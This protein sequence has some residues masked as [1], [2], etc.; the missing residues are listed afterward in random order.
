MSLFIRYKP[1]KQQ[2]MALARCKSPENKALVELFEM[3][4]RDVLEA[5]VVADDQTTINRLQG[6]A[7]VLKEF[8][9]AVEESQGVLER[10]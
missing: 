8:L 2:L 4:L 10:R 9:I 1:E 6:K 7:S 5:L 3:V